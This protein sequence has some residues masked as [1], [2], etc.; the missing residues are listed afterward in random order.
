MRMWLRGIVRRC[1]LAIDLRSGQGAGDFGDFLGAFIDEQDDQVEFPP[2]SRVPGRAHSL[3]DV[4]EEG[5]FAGAG[6]GYDQPALAAG[7]RRHEVEHPGGVAFRRGF[8][9]DP[10]GRVDRL[11]LVEE[12]KLGVLLGVLAIDLGD[13]DELGAAGAFPVDAIDPGTDAQ[14]VAAD[15]FGWHEDIVAGLLEVLLRAA[16]EAEALGGDFQQALPGD[17]RAGELRATL[18]AAFAIPFVAGFIPSSNRAPAPVRC[19]SHCAGR[20]CPCA[21]CRHPYAGCRHPY[22]GCRHPYVGCRHPYVGCR[23]PYVGC[24]HPYVGCHRPYVWLSP[25]LRWLSPSLRRPPDLPRRRPRL[26]GPPLIRP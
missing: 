17:F 23:H 24:R 1:E 7:H 16:Q 20:H 12:G 5:G 10:A 8:E 2:G 15:Q 25:S 4:L 13:L 9:D 21:G 18:V 19:R 6:R 3:G 22:V 11:E 26:T 14:S